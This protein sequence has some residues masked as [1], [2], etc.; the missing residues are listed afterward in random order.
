MIDD[1]VDEDYFIL[2]S[3]FLNA[4]CL[5]YDILLIIDFKICYLESRNLTKQKNQTNEKFNAIQEKK[6]INCLKH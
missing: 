1:G 5:F 2:F 4:F 6:Q 3:Y